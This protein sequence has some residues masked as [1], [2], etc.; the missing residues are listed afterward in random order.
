MCVRLTVRRIPLSF[1]CYGSG[2]VP[3]IAAVEEICS[4]FRR[5]VPRKYVRSP[6]TINGTWS[7]M[8]HVSHGKRLENISHPVNVISE[9]GHARVSETSSN[10]RLPRSR[11]F[12]LFRDR[13]RVPSRSRPALVRGTRTFALHSRLPSLLLRPVRHNYLIRDSGFES[14]RLAPRARIADR[15]VQR[16]SFSIA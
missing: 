15:R 4:P 6:S 5:L 13:S 12:L 8:L 3:G 11:A 10:L 16:A 7:A 1:H 9:T 14:R 2:L